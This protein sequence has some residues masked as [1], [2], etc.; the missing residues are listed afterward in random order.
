MGPIRMFLSMGSPPH[1]ASSKASLIRRY[2]RQA[3]EPL[4]PLEEDPLWELVGMDQG[5]P[6]DSMSI[7][8]VVY[9]PRR[10]G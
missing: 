3:V 8:D 2:V 10:E 6:D 5:Q 7:D 9:G 1:F 4:P